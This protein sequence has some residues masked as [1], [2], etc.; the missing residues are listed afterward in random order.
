MAADFYNPL[1]IEKGFGITIIISL[2]LHIVF[3]SAVFLI[4]HNNAPVVFTTPVYTVDLIGH[5]PEA[6]PIGSLSKPSYSE[7]S[8]VQSQKTVSKPAAKE[9]AIALKKEKEPSPALDMQGQ[10]LEEALKKVR[11]RVK[12]R[13]TEDTINKAVQDIENKQMEKRIKEIRDKVAHK[14]DIVKP[15]KAVPESFNRG[16]EAKSAELSQ[17]GSV[18]KRTQESEEKYVQ[19]IGDIIH[20]KWN[21]TGDIREGEVAV[22]ALRIDK[23]GRLIESHT[24]QSYGSPLFV[25]SAVRSIEKAAPLFPPFPTELEKDF[26]EIGVCFPEC[27]KE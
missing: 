4:S 7:K 2:C 24:E 27:K 21:Y 13:E 25:Q 15:V 23:A 19:L 3:L 11:Q 12:K 8:E 6:K 9:T 17:K 1:E 18:V 20:D 26:I 14:K 16:S 10:A 5:L 22:I